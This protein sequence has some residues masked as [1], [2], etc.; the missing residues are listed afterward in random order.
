MSNMSIKAL[1]VA[2]ALVT[3][4]P[5]HAVTLN[6]DSGWERFSFFGVGTTVPRT[7][8]FTLAA[9]AFLTVVD[10]FLSGDRFEVFA[11]LISL[12]QT[13]APV[14]NGSAVGMRF[15]DA[16]TDPDF[17]SGRFA[18]GPGTYRISF[19]VTERQGTDSERHLGALRVDTASVPLPA[20]GALLLS[21]LGLGAWLRRRRKT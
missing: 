12:G 15:D 3:A 20:G 2:A 10:G 19:L 5:S 16:L 11:N 17:S 1:A 4:G 6:V 8:D 7:F 18:L 21:G 13:S 14:D 9:N